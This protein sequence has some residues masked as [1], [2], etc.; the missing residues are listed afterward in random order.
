MPYHST[1]SQRNRKEC[2]NMIR[3]DMIYHV[4]SSFTRFANRHL[5]FCRKGF[6]FS[7]ASVLIELIFA[8]VPTKIDAPHR[9][10]APRSR[11]RSSLCSFA[12]SLSN[13]STPLLRCEL[14]NLKAAVRHRQRRF[15]PAAAARWPR[16]GSARAG[17]R[18]ISTAKRLVP[19]PAR[20]R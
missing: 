6:L 5:R 10:I 2:F 19:G 17:P 20:L 13:A 12:S 3:Y 15:Q 8:L 16:P 1:S 11:M 9:R 14:H 18:A 7:S 4:H